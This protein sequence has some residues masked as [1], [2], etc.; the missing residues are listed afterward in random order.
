MTDDRPFF[1]GPVPM[2]ALACLACL[3]VFAAPVTIKAN[4]GFRPKTVTAAALGLGPKEVLTANFSE[5]SRW[6]G[7]HHYDDVLLR[8]AIEGMLNRSGPLVFLDNSIWGWTGDQ[9][10]LAYYHNKYGYT[11]RRIKPGLRPLLERTARVFN[12]II[13]YDPEPSDNYFLAANLANINF[14]LP[15]SRHIYDEDRDAFK[16][17]PIVA[18]VKRNAYTRAEI[19][20][21]LIDKVLPLTDRTMAY[22]PASSFPDLTLS[23]SPWE[24][25]IVGGDYPF[26]RKGLL[27]NLSPYSAP[28]GKISGSPVLAESFRRLME[29]LKRPAAIFGWCVN[30][31]EFSAY[32]HYQCCST[33]APNLSFHAAVKPLKPPPYRQDWAPHPDKP[34]PKV[35]LAFVANE[36]DTAVVLTQLYYHAWLDPARGKLPMNWAIDP[37]YAKLFPALVEYFYDTKTPNDHFVCGPTGAGYVH[38]DE[39]PP[40]Y[41]RDFVGFTAR[42]FHNYL[43]L[44][45]IVMWGAQRPESLNA[46]ADGIPGLL[47]M[48][49]E[50]DGLYPNGDVFYAGKGRVP[51]VR[52]AGGHYWQTQK[53]FFNTANGY[54]LKVADAVGFF[55]DLYDHVPKP[56]YYMVYGLQDNIPGELVKLAA[57]LDPAKFEIVDLGT[58]MH[59]AKRSAPPLWDA[60]MIHHAK[61][62]RPSNGALVTA[63]PGG[64]QVKIAPGKAWAIATAVGLALPPEA[65]RLR[66]KVSDVHG[67][68]WVVKMT[69]EF[70]EKPG[71]EDWVPMGEPATPGEVTVTIDKRVR[72]AMV[73]GKPISL[74]LGLSGSPG[75]YAVFQKVQFL[76]GP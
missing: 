4:L 2:A 11:F 49:T 72:A 73:L 53:R 74:Q 58:L 61:A 29:G 6:Q 64:L 25:F 18:E 65:T 63:G 38:P 55:N 20:D 57:A 66:V 21:F 48:T 26:Y 44:R 28:V 39:M 30:E 40:A 51:V 71:Q 22:T 31:A 60:A 16:G 9:T 76:G 33:A 52:E 13:L 59:L 17:L 23:A 45:E 43:P 46:F 19:Y 1:H 75:A 27:F 35:Y 50:P 5:T 34:E 37:V 12:G 47:G 42:I 54:H 7:T 32:G 56:W 14:C 67:G 24:E 62:W 69:G 68:R 3:P 15:V 36:G 8:M 70:N 10:W 41:L